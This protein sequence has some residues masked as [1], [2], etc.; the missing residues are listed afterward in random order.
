MGKDMTEAPM[1]INHEP[2]KRLLGTGIKLLAVD[3]TTGQ[4]VNFGV[5]LNNTTLEI[6]ALPNL[7][8]EVIGYSDMYEALKEGRDFLVKY[9]KA[10]NESPTYLILRR[11]N[12]ALTKARKDES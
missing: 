7:N 3:D 12:E 11:M 6:E 5:Q 1:N 9:H 4:S 2:V 10:I 8:V